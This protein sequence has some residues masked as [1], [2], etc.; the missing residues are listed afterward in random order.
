MRKKIIAW[1][2]LQ[3][4]QSGARGVVIGLSGGLDSCV[5]AALARQA[6]GR[7][8]VLALVLPC[9]S[10]KQDSQDA[11]LASQ[12]LG[13]WVKTIDLSDIYDK[14]V[15]VLP[16]ANQR[17]RTNLKPR[18]RMLVLYYF[19]NKL[20]YLVCGTSNKSELLTGYFTKYGDGA[21]DIL[22]IAGL[23]KRQVRQLA[24]EI[25]IPRRII[26]KAPT[27]GLKPG[28]TDEADMGISYLE[29]DEILGRLAY[30]KGQAAPKTAVAK[31]IRMHTGSQ[32]KRQMPR[33]YCP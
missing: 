14:L 6:L 29:L 26:A 5:V 15:R 23:L 32:H 31:V 16:P 28:Q 22:P 27:A 24:V 11:R 20:N 19:A 18:L 21:A 4:K 25:G 10:Q 9:H 8:K 17:A 12:K 13:I 1:I 30:K 2:K 33:M 7:K 3:V